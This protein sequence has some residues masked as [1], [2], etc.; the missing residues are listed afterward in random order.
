MSLF[1]PVSRV[2]VLNSPFNPVIKIS[3]TSCEG[4]AG[5]LGNPRLV[6]ELAADLFFTNAVVG[7][8]FQ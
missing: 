8:S 3:L 1:R 4:V 2:D 5:G 6:V 7:I